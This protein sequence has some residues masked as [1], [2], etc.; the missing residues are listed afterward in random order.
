M[1][2]SIV[3][4]L[5]IALIGM[6]SPKIWAFHRI[7]TIYI[8]TADR[9]AIA[10]RDEWKEGTRLR[11]LA[12]DISRWQA[13]IEPSAQTDEKL[14]QGKDPARFDTHDTFHASISN[15][16]QVYLYRINSLN[17]LLLKE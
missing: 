9:S 16:K 6:I 1:K 8:T 13:L 17:K 3:Y 15:L 7:P 12:D 11:K 10:S 5:W 14:W 4:A 2:K